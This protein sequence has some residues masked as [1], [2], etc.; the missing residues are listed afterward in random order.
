[1]ITIFTMAF[2]EEIIL[3]FM[4]EHYRSRFPNCYIVLRDNCSTDSTVQI[5]KDNNCEIIHYDTKGLH[6][7][8]ELQELKNNC[9]K[10]ANTDWVLIVDPDE[11]LDINEEQLKNEERLGTTLIATTGYEMINMKDNYDLSSIKYG[12]KWDEYGKKCLFNKKYISDINYNCGA[13]VSNPAGNI[14]Y[15][16]YIYNIYH[17]K[18]I[19]QEYILNRFASTA[20]RMSESNKKHKMGWENMEPVEKIKEQFQ[21]RRERIKNE[22]IKLF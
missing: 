11:L 2:N 20:S 10:T 19:S 7:D 9:W 17:Y 1:M 3:P 6:D 21:I 15:S 4:I 8:F 13:H 5:A 22:G 16:Q 18:W 12:L 14:Q